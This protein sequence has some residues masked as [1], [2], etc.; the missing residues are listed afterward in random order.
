MDSFAHLGRAFT[1]RPSLALV[2]CNQG[3]SAV[4][5]MEVLCQSRHIEVVQDM[6]FSKLNRLKETTIRDRSAAIIRDVRRRVRNAPQLT[7]QSHDQLRKLE[8]LAGVNASTHRDDGRLRE[9]RGRHRSPII[10]REFPAA[11][12]PRPT[13]HDVRTHNP[14]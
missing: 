8:A 5:W 1:R 14:Q 3:Y 4:C 9:G 12:T 13:T 11:V 10:S 6:T 2:R 7:V